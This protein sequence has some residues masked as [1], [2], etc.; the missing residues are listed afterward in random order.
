MLYVCY[1]VFFIMFVEIKFNSFD[2]ILFHLMVAPRL[3]NA[4][5]GIDI[6]WYDL[7]NVP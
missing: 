3:Y 1:N 5:Y 4:Y 6:N 2:I 7:C